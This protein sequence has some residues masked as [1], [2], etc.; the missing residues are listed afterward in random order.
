MNFIVDDSK[1]NVVELFRNNDC[2]SKQSETVKV[3][4][5]T[6]QSAKS[7]GSVSQ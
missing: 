5:D 1:K 2:E 4:Y 7:K 3:F 6:Y